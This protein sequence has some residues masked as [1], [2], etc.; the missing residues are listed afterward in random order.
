M[1]DINGIITLGLGPTTG[2]DIEHLVLFGLNGAEVAVSDAST[3]RHVYPYS[4]KVMPMTMR[5]YP[6]YL[7]V[8]PMVIRAQ[9][10]NSW[11]RISVTPYV[12]G[13]GVY[14]EARYS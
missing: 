13:V 10:S 11:S 9:A 8:M 1:A 6:S 3:F 2:S 12:Y 4:I 7:S 5:A 14:G